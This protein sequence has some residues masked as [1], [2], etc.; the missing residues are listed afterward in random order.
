[1]S[2]V[3][4]MVLYLMK[5]MQELSKS[6]IIEIQINKAGYKNQINYRDV[7]YDLILI[8]DLGNNN[9]IFVLQIELVNVVTF[10]A[11]KVP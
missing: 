10:K 11:N 1:M 2:L 7:S 5:L 3:K 8:G 4:F 6:A 9:I